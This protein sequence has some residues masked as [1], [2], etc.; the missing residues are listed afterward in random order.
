M[1]NK[2]KK[3]FT[4]VEIMIVVVII[5][6]LAAIAIP[7]LN[8]ARTKTINNSMANDARQVAGA[9][10]L[11]FLE[12]PTE[13]DVS[14]DELVTGKYLAKKNPNITYPAGDYK[15]TDTFLLESSGIKKTFS[16]ETGE[17]V[18]SSEPNDEPETETEK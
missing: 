9:A 6:L 3:G 5:G 1:K 16:F 10:Q 12:K 11:Y 18:T 13:A 7:N 15:P 8:N 2:S 14:I 17:L 4:L